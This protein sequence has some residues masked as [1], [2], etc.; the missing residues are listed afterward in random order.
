MRWQQRNKGVVFLFVD[1]DVSDCCPEKVGA[2]YLKNVGNAEGK[3]GVV[4]N[5]MASAFWVSN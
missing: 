1:L 2:I 5:G 4:W 3:S